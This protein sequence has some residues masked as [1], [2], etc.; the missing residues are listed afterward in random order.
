M[1]VKDNP[2]LLV[3]PIINSLCINSEESVDRNQISLSMPYSQTT[4]NSTRNFTI[5]T[6]TGE[7]IELKT[8]FSF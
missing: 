4:E 8:R 5:R 6:K 7:S 3:N 2:I 1:G